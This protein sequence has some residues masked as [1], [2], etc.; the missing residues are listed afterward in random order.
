[1]IPVEAK[2]KY[3]VY[4]SEISDIKIDGRVITLT[5]PSPHLEL[6]SYQ[7][8]WDDVVENVGTLR[9]NYSVREKKSIAKEAVYDLCL[10]AY[11]SKQFVIAANNVAE[12]QLK[13]L[14]DNYGY[15]AVVNFT[16]S[17][18]IID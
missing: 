10:K 2:F 14:F 16:I 7:I 18:P 9:S 11:N 6:E 17:K 8:V 5:M 15:D 1:M 4:F 12:K 13:A 3:T